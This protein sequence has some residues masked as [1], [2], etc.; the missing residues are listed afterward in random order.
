MT[1]SDTVYLS[2]K[3]WRYGIIIKRR[4]FIKAMGAG[5]VGLMLGGCS[6]KSPWS[7][8]PPDNTLS[9]DKN[10]PDF[11]GTVEYRTLRAGAKISTIGLGASALHESSAA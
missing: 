2:G 7:T 3:K 1:S 4:D 11:S 5:A 8:V 10:A 6:F 9:A